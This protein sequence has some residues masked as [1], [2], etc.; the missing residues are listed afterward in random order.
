MGLAIGLGYYAISVLGCISIV[1][2]TLKRFQ[3]KFIS[4][5]GNIKICIQYTNKGEVMKF[6][7]PKSLEINELLIHWSINESIV[8]IHE[9]K[10]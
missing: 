10:E 8:K 5:S 9:I 3:K 7:A 2:V 4:N 6:I 1:L